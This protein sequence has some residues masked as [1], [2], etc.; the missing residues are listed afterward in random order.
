V[1]QKAKGKPSKDYK[2]VSVGDYS[3]FLAK[4]KSGGV[5]VDELMNTHSMIILAAPLKFV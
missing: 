2:K 4:G 5:K 1:L 3:S